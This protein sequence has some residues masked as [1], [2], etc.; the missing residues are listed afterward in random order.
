MF[1]T[2]DLTMDEIKSKIEKNKFGLFAGMASNV[3]S[4]ICGINQNI[5][6]TRGAFDPHVGR[7]TR[8]YMKSLITT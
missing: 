8:S 5:T 4:M 1:V 6:W 2:I 7:I 3:L